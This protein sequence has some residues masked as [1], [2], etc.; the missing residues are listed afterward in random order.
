MASVTGDLPAPIEQA[1][2][3][4]ALEAMFGPGGLPDPATPLGAA[5]LWYV[6]LSNLDDPTS[7]EQVKIRSYNPAAWDYPSTA[8]AIKGWSLMQ[9]VDF[10]TDDPDI[11]YVKLLR[12]DVSGQAFASWKIP[13]EDLQ[14]LTL[15]R[16]GQ[17]YVWA[18]PQATT[19][20]APSAS[21]P[22][23]TSAGARPRR[24]R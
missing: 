22:A 21:A 10:A 6:F 16:D 18:S 24:A 17:W 9:N 3:E 8:A 14:H 20:R 5:Y 4:D 7:L 13:H 15:V 1:S 23:R 2:D 11:A 19:G 12:G